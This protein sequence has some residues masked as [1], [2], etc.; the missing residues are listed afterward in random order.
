MKNPLLHL[1]MAPRKWLIA[2]SLLALFLICFIWFVPWGNK[3]NQTTFAFI[4]K[5]MT[6]SE[7]E[8]IFGGPAHEYVK[9]CVLGAE[10]SESFIVAYWYAKQE[11]IKIEFYNGKVFSKRLLPP[12]RTST[13][14]KTFW[15]D[16]RRVSRMFGL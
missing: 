1:R 9:P 16:L 5:D 11:T 3:A 4:N 12:G 13:S 10:P 15:S 6:E 2:F 8:A 14:E 7:V